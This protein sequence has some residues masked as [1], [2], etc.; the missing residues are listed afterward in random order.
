[1]SRY[2]YLLDIVVGVGAA[3]AVLVLWLTRRWAWWTGPAYL[4]GCALGATWEVTFTV[5]GPQF[6]A[7]PMWVALRPWPLWWPTEPLVHSLWD[8][9]LFLAGAGLVRLVRGAPAFRRWRAADLALLVLWGLG[10]SAV[11][12]FAANGSLWYYLPRPANPR[13][14]AVAGREYT[15]WPLLTWALATP[16]FHLALLVLRRRPE[17]PAGPG[18]GAPAE[19]ASR[20]ELP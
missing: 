5:L 15:L 1:M 7:D 6:A 17:A 8:G 20:A 12:E 11:V 2:G 3:V 9:A 14:F 4:V 16:V 18:P 13:L 19:A 10:T